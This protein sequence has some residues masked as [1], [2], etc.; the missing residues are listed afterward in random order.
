MR[1]RPARPGRAGRHL[2]QARQEDLRGFECRYLWG[3]CQD[4]SKYTLRGH[5][6]GL[7]AA[8]LAP[9]GQ[10]LATRGDD[11][12]VRLWDMDSRRHVKLLG[13]WI[14]R[15]YY[16][17][18]LAFAP[19]G[20][21]SAIAC[22]SNKAV[23]LWDVAARCERATLPHRTGGVALAFSPDGKLLATG[24]N[25]GSVHLWDLATRREV[26]SLEGHTNGV[27]YIA[28]APNGRTLA[29]SSWDMT[30]RLWDVVQRSAIATLRGHTGEVKCL[31][32]SPDGKT[33][34]AGDWQGVLRL[35]DVAEK[36]LLA[37]RQVEVMVLLTLAFAPDGRRLV[38]CGGNGGVKFW[39][40][41]LLRQLDRL[42]GHDG[43]EGLRARE[44]LWAA[45]SLGAFTE[46]SRRYQHDSI[47]CR[48]ANGN[49]VDR[50]HQGYQDREL[51]AEWI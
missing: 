41:A 14:G 11:N 24:C 3:L 43:S 7:S 22:D 16:Y 8:A 27:I 12:I 32:F 33:L 31:A 34:A 51:G 37:S 17:G 6:G 23:H 18:S 9:D 49:R 13:Y 15:G 21:T 1:G 38:T 50:R 2:P 47:R 42:P 36:R 29:S 4:G 46:G 10:T 44:R 19:D 28:F 25:D 45:A 40:A 39:N 5:T 30:V 35:W 20:K 48:G 26:S